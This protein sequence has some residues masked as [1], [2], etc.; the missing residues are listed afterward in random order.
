[1]MVGKRLDFALLYW[2]CGVGVLIV[3]CCARSFKVDG[4]Y[5]R[6]AAMGACS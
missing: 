3:A 2:V 1:M 5:V 4:S 6:A